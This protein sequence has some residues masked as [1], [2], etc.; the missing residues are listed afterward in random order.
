MTIL[1][2]RPQFGDCA[3]NLIS[4]SSQTVRQYEVQLKMMAGIK[5]LIFALVLTGA[6]GTG[7]VAGMEKMPLERAIQIHEDNL[8]QNSTMPDKCLKG[9]Q[10]ALDHLRQNQERWLANHVDLPDEKAL[11]NPDYA[12]I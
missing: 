12:V 6:G 8:G 1:A 3:T 11:G 5:A 7:V 2:P 9:Q 10:T 4:A